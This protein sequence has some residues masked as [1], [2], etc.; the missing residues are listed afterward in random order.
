[1]KLKEPQK[2]AMRMRMERKVGNLLELK[3]L[4]AGSFIEE[5]QS[6]FRHVFEA[7]FGLEKQI[8]DLVVRHWGKQ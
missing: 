8:R 6:D 5:L 7:N 2:R 4:S 1:M 3:H